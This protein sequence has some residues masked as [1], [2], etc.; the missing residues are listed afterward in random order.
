MAG[1]V[2]ACSIGIANQSCPRCRLAYQLASLAVD[3]VNQKE[4]D[5]LLSCCLSVRHSLSIVC[6]DVP[7]CNLKTRSRLVAAS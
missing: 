4:S 7:R 5:E 1:H 3:G 2:L 6:G